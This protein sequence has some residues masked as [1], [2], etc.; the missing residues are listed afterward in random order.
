MRRVPSLL[1]LPASALARGAAALLVVLGAAL[2]AAAQ[3]VSL[4]TVDSAYSQNF[5]TLASSGTSSTLPTGWTF[6]ESGTNANSL[7]NT[8]TGSGNAGDTYSFGSASTTERAFGGLQSNSLVP[9]I[10]AAFTNNTGVTIRSLE[11]TYVGEQW[12]IGNAGAA[13]DDRMDFQYSVDATSLTTGTW[14]DANDLDFANRVKTASAGA[15]DGNAAANRLAISG[16]IGGL[17]ILPG[18]TVWLRW[19][20]FNA[21]GADD[22]LAVDDF[23]LTPRATDVP[24]TPTLTINDVALA[25]GNAGTTTFTFT[26]TLSAPALAGGVTFDIATADNTAIGGSDFIATALTGQSIPAGSTSYAFDVSVTGDAVVEANE[27]FFVQVTNLVGANPVDLQGQGTILND[28]V[29]LTAIN[30]IQGPGSTSPLAGATVTTLGVVTGVKNNG[31]FIQTADADVDADPNTSE[32]LF[33]FTSTAPPPAAVVGTLV[34]VTGTILEFVPTSAAP[35]I[36]PLTE[37]T[38]PTVVLRGTAPLPAV[39]ALSTT[40]FATYGAAERYEG[41]LVSV[42]PVTVVAPTDGNVNEPNAT[43][44]ST[45]VFWAVLT[46]TPRPFREPGLEVFTPLPAGAPATVTRYD[47]NPERLR[48]DSDGVGGPVLNVATGATVSGLVGVLDVFGGAYSL[49]PLAGS[50]PTASGGVAV[51]SV[52][53]ASPSEVTVGS[54][55]FERFFDTDNAPGISDPV[56]T[57]TAFD[58]RLAKASLTVRNVLRS[59]DILAVVEMENLATLQALAARIN[60][61]ALAATS[62]DP[63]YQAFLIEGNDIGGIDVGFLVKN[64]TTVVDVTQIGKDATYVDPSD[65]Q[66][67]L[68]NDR[69][70]LVLKAVVTPAAGSPFPLTVIAN[71]LRSLN[72]VDSTEQPA[73]DLATEGARVRAK[74]K[75][76]AEFLAAFIQGR[77]DADAGER[78]LLVGDFNAFEFSDGFVDVIGTITGKPAAAATV[79]TP[80]ADLVTPDLINLVEW[81]PPAE[82]YSYVFEGNAQ[83]LDHALITQNLSRY[84]S[85]ITFS[86]SNADQPETARG[87]AS[88]PARLSDHDGVVVAFATG[89]PRIVSQV[90]GRGPGSSTVDVRLTNSGTGNAFNVTVDGAT[91]RTLLGSGTVSL[92]GPLPAA[93]P[94]LAPGQSQTVRFQLNVPSSVQRFVLT[95]SGTYQNAEGLGFRFSGSLVVVNTLVAQ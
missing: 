72:G 19:S 45:G 93:I 14:T 49:L 85:R 63:Q 28:D 9:T 69:P 1:S 71:H 33:V 40:D 64:T 77:Q 5:N 80:T 13:R 86:R 44:T 16:V 26:V 81:V 32:G 36:Q 79:V 62:V 46:G 84:V 6:A 65:G 50:T 31:F 90:V 20:D 82:R 12:R 11:I 60:G 75:A 68:L 29:T 87:D 76:Q 83:V 37:L 3:T 58:N 15:L 95:Q 2:P 78:I 7:Y 53:A 54:L 30:Q 17:T 94:V 70:S 18:Q 89:T 39:T 41:M 34:Q 73:G 88:S 42:P 91:F 52:P 67:A 21:N 55:N 25:E 22:G 66:P 27:T 92:A 61:D 8:G 51:T 4:T 47:S 59:P 48:V 35:G 24:V 38:S 23:T 10:G 57:A 74:R 56:L 43:A